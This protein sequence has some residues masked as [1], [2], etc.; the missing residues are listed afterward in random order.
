[1]HPL[2]RIGEP[3][4]IASGILWL[5]DPANDWVTGQIIGI[6]GGLGRVRSNRWAMVPGD[7]AP[8]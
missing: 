4:D 7:G 6:D 2:A 3:Q 1:M 8:D 5:L